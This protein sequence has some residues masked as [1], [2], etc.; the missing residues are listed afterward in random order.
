MV[1][2]I[3]GKDDSTPSA[4][5]ALA[6]D[7]AFFNVW[8]FLW[9]GGSIFE[10][11]DLHHN[12]SNLSCGPQQCRNNKHSKRRLKSYFWNLFFLCGLE[13][14]QT[15]RWRQLLPSLR[16]WCRLLVF[17]RPA[18]LAKSMQGV[19]ISDLYQDVQ[20]KLGSISVKGIAWFGR[21][22]ATFECMLVMCLFGCLGQVV[23]L[24]FSFSAR[25]F[26]S[27]T[28]GLSTAT[29]DDRAAAATNKP[30]SQH[31]RMMRTI[32]GIQQKL[33]CH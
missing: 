5:K 2:S 25:R 26:S 15:G 10:S 20:A 22:R 17:L 27:N 29:A 18:L 33:W 13:Q 12:C 7:R 24:V 32:R 6:N 11:P 16:Y 14:F 4:E 23:D 21:P 31:L 1:C 9:V 28:Y 8:S 30:I 3:W 19:K